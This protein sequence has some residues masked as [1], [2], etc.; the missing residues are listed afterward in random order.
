MGPYGERT[1]VVFVPI[2]AGQI[3]CALEEIITNT[4]PKESEASEILEHLMTAREA[5]EMASSLLPSNE[6]MHKI[7]TEPPRPK[8]D[9][10]LGVPFC[11]TNGKPVELIQPARLAR[12]SQVAKRQSASRDKDLAVSQSTL[13]VASYA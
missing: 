5:L 6:K 13:E 10:T 11:S 7:L 8:H 9:L 1:T 4:D 12:R 2:S 3:K